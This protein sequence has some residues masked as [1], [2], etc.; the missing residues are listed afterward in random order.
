M[1]HLLKIEWLKV[2][3]YAAFKVM[4]L[5]FIIG[6]FALNYIVFIVNKNIVKNVPGAGLVSFSPYDFE[7]TWQS[8]S[9][10][11]G[12]ILILPAL[13][14]LMLFTNEYTFKTHR[15]NIIDGLSRQQF[16]SVKIMMAVIFAF[17]ATWLVIISALIFGFA[18]GTSFSIKGIEFTGFFFLKALTYNIIAVL[19]SVIVK[20]TGFAIGIFFI[21]LGSEN[22]ISQLLNVLSIKMKQENRIDLGNLGD[23]LPMNAAD[24]LLE[25][26]DNPIKSMSKSIMPTDYTWLVFAL[27]L[28]YLIIFYVW[29]RRK[30]IH[31]DL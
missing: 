17:A 7:N 11:T 1:M 31:A 27:A 18:S 4:V 20:R 5:F 19:F 26:P 13:L 8:T 16:I 23:Y 2:K 28:A 10:A 9:Y 25:F 21:Y 29:S 3:N 15:Q 22:I 14:L 30:F 12:F 24:A 6:V